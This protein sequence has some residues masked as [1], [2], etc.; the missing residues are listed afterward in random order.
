MNVPIFEQ[1]TCINFWR[2]SDLASVYTSDATIMTK[3]DKQVKN[4]PD[5]WRLISDDGVG[6]TYETTKDLISFRAR[7]T[8]RVMTEEQR[9]AAA[10]RLAMARAKKVDTKNI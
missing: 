6:K 9:K 1:E 4:N 10:E 5:Y 7:K 8:E 3:L 2:D